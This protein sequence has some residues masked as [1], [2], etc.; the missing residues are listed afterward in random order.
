MYRD[1]GDIN[2][3]EKGME[4]GGKGGGKGKKKWPRREK[5]TER[6]KYEGKEYL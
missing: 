5:V 2:Y 6:E 4:M 1:P 3:C